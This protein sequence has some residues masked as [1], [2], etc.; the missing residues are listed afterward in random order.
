M[1]KN[2]QSKMV[3]SGPRGQLIKRPVILV[4]R[5]GC[6][7]VMMIAPLEYPATARQGGSGR[8]GQQGPCSIDI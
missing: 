3:E 2:V 1:S 8:K 7:L 5:F 6:N 4:V